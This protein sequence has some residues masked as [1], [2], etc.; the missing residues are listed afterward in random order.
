MPYGFVGKLLEVDLSSEKIREIGLREELLR[1]FIGGRGLGSWLLWKRLGERWE[2]LDPLSPENQLM[3]L[4]G[5][6][7]GYYPGT[8]ICVTGKS[9]LS[10]GVIGSTVGTELG[11]ELKTSGYDGLIVTG[12]ASSPVYIF[13]N[14]DKVEIRDASKHWGKGG[15]E[16]LRDLIRETWGELKSRNS[17]KG[18]PKEPSILYRASWRES[19]QVCC[20]NVEMDSCGRIWRVWSCHGI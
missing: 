4:T 17:L 7:T 6:M 2:N 20:N 13:V 1:K 11:L 3:F 8:R 5:P 10:N 14:D 19:S 18:I 15:R 16:T 9:P 12:K